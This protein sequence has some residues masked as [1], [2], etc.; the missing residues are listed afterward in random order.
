MA[1]KKS[2]S[3][4]IIVP[5]ARPLFQ[6]AVKFICMSSIP[7]TS[8]HNKSFLPGHYQTIV[9][10]HN[11][12]TKPVRFRTKLAWPIEISRYFPGELKPD[13]VV[14][15]SCENIHEY[16]LHLIHG[17]EGFLVIESVS[18]LD[19]SAVYMAGDKSVASIDVEQIKERKLR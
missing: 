7:G 16:G 9:N 13:G 18:S 5:P 15:I 4:P 12:S 6:Y 19:V 14:A 17:F 2:S 8:Q 1:A 11:P 3:K 10:I